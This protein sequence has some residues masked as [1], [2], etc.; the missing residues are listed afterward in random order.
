MEF[1]F[2]DDG[3][4]LDIERLHKKAIQLGIF[5]EDEAVNENQIM[6]V[7]FATGLSTASGVSEISGRGVGMDVVR[8]DIMGLGG[9]IDVFSERDK[10]ARFVIHLP[11]TLAVAQ[12][13]MIQAAHETYA[14]NGGIIEQVQQIKHAGLVEIY[15]KG[16]VEWNGNHYPLFNLMR[17]LG[18]ENY[19]PESRPYNPVLLLRSGGRRLALHVD[20]LLGNQ[21][22]VI[23]NIGP[24]LARLPGIAGATVLGNGKVVLILNPIALE[25]YASGAQM[26]S[27]AKAA[28]A[29]VTVAAAKLL[30]MVVDDSL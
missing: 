22:V 29:P 30:V 3:A 8:S 28:V 1:E 25:Q 6:Q 5:K 13:L 21:E 20:G 19:Q 4:G 14:I 24:Q 17:L 7:I 15:D 10:G 9:R 11:L 12:T 18:N 23:K 26:I 2:T 16:E 27:K